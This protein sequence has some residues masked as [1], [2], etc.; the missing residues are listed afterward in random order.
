MTDS[1]NAKRDERIA[2]AVIR[3]AVERV[4]WRLRH[5]QLPELLAYAAN[6]CSSATDAA[7]ELLRRAYLKGA[8]RAEKG[9]PLRISRGPDWQKS[10][11]AA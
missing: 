10:R 9:N 7:L 4:P 11:S 5:L 6:D 3:E 1:V 2:D 8:R